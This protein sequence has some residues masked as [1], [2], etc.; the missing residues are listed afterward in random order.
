MI[1]Q[2]MRTAE[3]AALFG[4]NPKTVKRWAKDGV[5][6]YLLTPGGHFRFPAKEVREMFERS[7]R[8]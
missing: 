7:K 8:R 6:P 5:I 4:V 3:V 2:P 1:E